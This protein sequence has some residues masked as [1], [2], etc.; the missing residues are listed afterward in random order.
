M[1]VLFYVF[2][3]SCAHVRGW[4]NESFQAYY[5]GLRAL[6]SGGD[7]VPGR[8]NPQDVRDRAYGYFE[9]ALKSSNP[10]VSRDAAGRLIL[11]LLQGRR[12]GGTRF[13]E[14]TGSKALPDGGRP[15]A[16]AAL[17]SQGRYA[18]ITA[19]Y[20]RDGGRETGRP[21][22]SGFLTESW[23][24]WDR[25]FP[26]LA[27]L[28]EAGDAGGLRDFIFGAAPG[29]ALEWAAEEIRRSFPGFLSP[30]E[31]AALEGRFAA[32][33]SAFTPGLD[34][35][36]SVLA[37]TPELFLQYPALITDLG[38]CFQFTASGDQGI[39]LFLEW[40]RQA[41]SAALHYRLLYFAGRIARARGDYPRS[42]ELFTRAL[43]FVPDKIQEDACVW[44]IMDTALMDPALDPAGLV[45]TWASRWNDPAYFSDILDRIARRLASSGQW[46]RFPEILAL[47]DGAGDRAS[48]AK[49]AYIS[50]RAAALGLIPAAAVPD[51]EAAVRRYFR[52]AYE[53]GSLYY[54][55]LGAYFLGEPFLNFG[56]PPGK[57]PA[58]GKTRTS[59]A[60]GHPHFREMEF[61]LGFFDAGIPELAQPWVEA[62]TGE[63]SGEELRT[64]AE[65]METAGNHA[66]QIALI[67]ALMDRDE[68]TRRDLE[69][70]SP[71]PFQELIEG[72][73]RRTGLAPELL[74]GL[75]RTE[76]AFQAE[77]VSWA[78]AVGLTQLMP[79][80]AVDMAG[81]I[82][83]QG[84]P[85]YTG[86]INL[87]DPE[88]NVRIGS[89]YLAY[90]GD[91][92]EHPLLTILAYNGGMNRVRRWYREAAPGSPLPGDLFLETVELAETRNYGRKVIAAALVYGYLYY[93][94]KADSFLADI[95]R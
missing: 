18:E 46:R 27:R 29:E 28:Q 90:L 62:M 61:L 15:L 77:I 54:R 55:A 80:T 84:G 33:R 38:R 53:G 45:G 12:P 14:E 11:P 20:G 72:E 75:I 10:Y 31:D 79:A 86:A 85:D 4:E 66:G 51:G 71:R 26:L 50:G 65:V 21:A 92:L 56:K 88:I 78:G 32:A 91:L 81:R 35:F 30:A 76:S 6:E 49:Y 95:C 34:L 83:R 44:Y 25:L 9:T 69:L 2:L 48:T 64:L 17:Y 16:A 63:L 93:D 40:E 89:F 82:R 23:D 42:G 43:A 60:A 19:L 47:L 59:L 57:P 13:W 36:R 7:A 87:Q 1:L 8:T 73:A 74:Y 94:V 22:G 41:S 39:E 5:L 3:N 37:E 68:I 70:L 52:T 58:R 67:S 24:S